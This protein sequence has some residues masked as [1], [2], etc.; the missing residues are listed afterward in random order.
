MRVAPNSASTIFAV[1]A[2][3]PEATCIGGKFL[4]TGVAPGLTKEE[5]GPLAL[6]HYGDEPRAPHV[7]AA[8]RLIAANASYRRAVD[9][10]GMFARTCKRWIAKQPTEDHE[11]LLRLA[12]SL[13]SGTSRRVETTRQ[14]GPGG[15]T[16][17][18]IPSSTT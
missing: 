11:L 12:R 5:W 6:L 16:Y 8:S 10:I 18:P 7:T 13:S 14:F 3:H 9:P 17:A 15:G 4:Q 2:K 1:L